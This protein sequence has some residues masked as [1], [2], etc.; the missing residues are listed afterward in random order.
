MYVLYQKTIKAAIKIE[1]SVERRFQRPKRLSLKVIG[2]VQKY[3]G[4]DGSSKI[5][6]KVEAVLHSHSAR[7]KHIYVYICL[8]LALM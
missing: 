1:F 7:C 2:K 4:Q 5:I 6:G 3:R 8:H